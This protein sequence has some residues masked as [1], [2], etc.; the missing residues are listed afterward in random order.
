MASER[1]GHPIAGIVVLCASLFGVFVVEGGPIEV[2]LFPA[3]FVVVGGSILGAV[4][5]GCGLRAS[6]AELWDLLRGRP[7]RNVVCGCLQARETQEFYAT[8]EKSFSVA[9]QI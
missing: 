9:R 4:L 3:A 5:M 2:L 7:A 6:L 8:N 1:P